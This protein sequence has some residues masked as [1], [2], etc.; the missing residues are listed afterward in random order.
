MEV[1][2]VH[3]MISDKQ[4]IVQMNLK[5]P[6]KLRNDLKIR[7]IQRNIKINDLLIEYLLKGLKDDT[8]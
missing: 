6:E 2:K 1:R 4:R 7:A 5:V 3:N 8:E